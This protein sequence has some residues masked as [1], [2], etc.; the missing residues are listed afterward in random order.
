MTLFKLGVHDIRGGPQAIA[1]SRIAPI[2][3]GVGSTA[4]LHS[5]PDHAIRVY[6]WPF[7]GLEQSRILSGSRSDLGFLFDK[8]I[9]GLAGYRHP[10]LYVELLNEVGKGDR[11]DY[12]AV[13]RVAIPYFQ[14]VG[15]KVA[16]PSWATGDYE[17]EDWDAFKSLGWDA[18]ALHAYWSTA[19]ATIWNGLRW[20]M[21]RKDGTPLWQPGDPKVIVTECGR[22][23]VR[24]GPNGTWLPQEGGSNFGWQAQ[25]IDA[26]QYIR[27]LQDYDDELASDP[28]VLGATVFTTS[29]TDDWRDKGFSCDDIAARLAGMTKPGSILTPVPPTPHFPA[30]RPGMPAPA[31]I[32]V[33]PVAPAD[34]AAANAILESEV[35]GP[36]WRLKDTA[37]GLG[38]NALWQELFD[39][40]LEDKKRAGAQ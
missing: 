36:L 14:S 18:I 25:G 29:P 1:W 7:S 6:R 22:D 19:G 35:W 23:R 13:A 10:N 3:K 16:G 17:Q 27:E 15:I 26:D 31:P 34:R 5:A 33:P 20:R 32:P 12:C 30:P 37:A 21:A 11:D 2:V 9:W 24:D 38:R 39:A 4:V 8:L 40:I 28:R